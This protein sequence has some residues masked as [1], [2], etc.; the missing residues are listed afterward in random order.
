[1]L[2]RRCPDH[3]RQRP[4]ARAHRAAADRRVDELHAVLGEPLRQTGGDA[5]GRDRRH[6][7]HEQP[8]L[9]AGR[10]RR[11][12]RRARPRLA[13]RRE[14]RGSR[15]RRRPR[16]RR[17]RPPRSTPSARKRSSASRR[18]CALAAT[19]NPARRNERAIGSPIAPNPTNPT[20]AITS[21]HLGVG[22]RITFGTR[23]RR[24]RHYDSCRHS[25]GRAPDLRRNEPLD[26]KAHPLAPP[27]VRTRARPT[28]R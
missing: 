24:S 17:D 15:L 7:D 21:G 3:D 1:M 19:S 9:R 22:L 14:R 11:A 27:D 16:D 18:R 4:V 2:R 20:R 25:L 5:T 10:R 8:G 23:R 26:R 28:E 13:G 12:I 6:V